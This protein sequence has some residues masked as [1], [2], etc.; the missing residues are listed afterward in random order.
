MIEKIEN[1]FN[2]YAIPTVIIFTLIAQTLYNQVEKG[3][4]TW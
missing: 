4:L 1:D 2:N 3:L